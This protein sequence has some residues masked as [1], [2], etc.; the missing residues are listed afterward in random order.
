MKAFLFAA[1][2][3]GLIAVGAGFL[4]N[5]VGFSSPERTMSS[6]AVRLGDAAQ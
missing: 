1:V 5:G 2:M 3:V 4:L 6:S